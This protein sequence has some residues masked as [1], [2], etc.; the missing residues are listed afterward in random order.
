MERERQTARAFALVDSTPRERTVIQP[1]PARTSHWANV[2]IY[3][4]RMNETHIR[5]CVVSR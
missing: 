2:N 5:L 1:F 4:E 3:G